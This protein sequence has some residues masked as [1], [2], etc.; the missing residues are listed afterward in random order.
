MGPGTVP[1]LGVQLGAGQVLGRR[2]RPHPGEDAPGCG[3]TGSRAPRIG[4]APIGGSALTRVPQVGWAEFW[5]DR[6]L[7][8]L[9]W[10]DV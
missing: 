2:S 9:A 4:S 1:R 8:G 10:Q 7:V 5:P 3:R 6:Y